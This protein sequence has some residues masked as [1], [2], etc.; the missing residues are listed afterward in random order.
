MAARYLG[1]RLPQ[2]SQ[3]YSPL[4]QAFLDSLR[5]VFVETLPGL[6]AQPL[7]IDHTL[8]QDAGPV[9]GVAGT[10]VQRLLDGQTCVKTDTANMLADEA[11]GQGPTYKSAV[12]KLANFSKCLRLHV[13]NWS[14]PIGWFMP[15]F[16]VLSMSSRVATPCVFVRCGSKVPK[17]VHL[18]ETHN[19]LGDG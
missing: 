16:N 8:E 19:R 10:L 1:V 15:S 11:R 4:W 7:G 9:L 5:F 13:P 6:L 14:G 12:G 3:N 18:L 17:G 2:L